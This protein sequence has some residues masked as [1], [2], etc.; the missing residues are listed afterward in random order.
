MEGRK[1][2]DWSPFLYTSICAVPVVV[3]LDYEGR[4]YNL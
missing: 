1:Q 3:E 2:K 4:M